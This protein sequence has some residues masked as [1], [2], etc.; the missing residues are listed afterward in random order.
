M[1]NSQVVKNIIFLQ[2]KTKWLSRRGRA[3]IDEPLPWTKIVP[4][5][6]HKDESSKI[7]SNLLL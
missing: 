3:I 4:V 6:I 5:P 1:H 7:I 2:K